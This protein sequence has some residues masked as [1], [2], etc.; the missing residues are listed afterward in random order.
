MKPQ[1]NKKEQL[2][3]YN[4]RIIEACIGIGIVLFLAT[5][6]LKTT[7]W[8]TFLILWLIALGINIIIFIIQIIR[9]VIAKKRL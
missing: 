7:E 8:G 3:K 9:A 1:L 2:N 5:I 6:S 4:D